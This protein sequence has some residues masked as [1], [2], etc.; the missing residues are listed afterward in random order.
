MA[1]DKK[2][3]IKTHLNVF[4]QFYDFLFI[5]FIIHEYRA[6]SNKNVTKNTHRRA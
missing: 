1:E 2:K 5:I 4:Q 6:I 3:S